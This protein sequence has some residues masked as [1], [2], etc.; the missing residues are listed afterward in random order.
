MRYYHIRVRKHNT[1]REAVGGAGGGGG[2]I[3]HGHMGLPRPPNKAVCSSTSS[4][5]YVLLRESL[6]VTTQWQLAACHTRVGV[7][8]GRPLL[9]REAVR[10]WRARGPALA[11]RGETVHT[12]SNT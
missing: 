6:A 11:A 7:S 8:H 12:V 2:S 1:A 3:R 10:S 5:L 9:P 4:A